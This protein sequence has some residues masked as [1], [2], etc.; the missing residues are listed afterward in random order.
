MEVAV[1][2]L[3]WLRSDMRRYLEAALE[4]AAARTHRG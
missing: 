4:A 3:E 1:A 2:K